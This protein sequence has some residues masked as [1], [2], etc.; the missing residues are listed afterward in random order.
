MSTEFEH[1]IAVNE[2]A[3]PGTM[4]IEID[5]R[6]VVL[7]HVEG[8]FFGILDDGFTQLNHHDTCGGG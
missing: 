5:E 7:V 8:E 1:A 4:M 2:L 6:L 3:D